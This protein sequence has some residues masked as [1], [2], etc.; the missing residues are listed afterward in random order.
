M[1]EFY[2]VRTRAKVQVPESE[3]RKVVY[4][5]KGGTRYGFRGTHDGVTLTKFIS[6]ATYDA[7]SVAAE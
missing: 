6:K 3:V 5:T 4:Q 2:N 7:S 1:I